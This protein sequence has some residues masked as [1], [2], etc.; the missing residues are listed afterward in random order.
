MRSIRTLLFCLWCTSI[1]PGALPVEMTTRGDAIRLSCCQEAI[2]ADLHDKSRPVQS[3]FLPEVCFLN[4]H[5]FRMMAWAQWVNM[6][7]FCLKTDLDL[8]HISI[9]NINILAIIPRTVYFVFWGQSPVCVL[10]RN[11]TICKIFK[12]FASFTMIIYSFC[13][14]LTTL[15]CKCE[16]TGWEMWQCNIA[17]HLQRHHLELITILITSLP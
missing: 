4:K 17:Y 14:L 8:S 12:W 3:R 16:V 13:L 9:T 11:E 7:I 10:N 5:V 1:H 15:L 2:W 6:H